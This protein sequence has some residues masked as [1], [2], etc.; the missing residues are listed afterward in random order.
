MPKNVVWS[1]PIVG[2]L[3]A[4]SA[5]GENSSPTQPP[6]SCSY[7]LSVSSLSFGASGASGSVT[8][9]AAA[10]CS[11]AASSD[12]GWMNITGGASGAGNGVVSVSLTA[13]TTTIERTGT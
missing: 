7:S 1:L 5:C 9:T 13:N 10:Q 12:R 3:V 8:V 6:S 4:F 11:R 2:L